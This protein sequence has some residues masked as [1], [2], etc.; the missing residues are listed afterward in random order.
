MGIERPY[1]TLA[2]NMMLSDDDPFANEPTMDVVEPHHASAA[3]VVCLTIVA[4][5]D[6]K[7]IGDRFLCRYSGCNERVPITRSSPCFAAPTG[8]SARAL[9]DPFLS[10]T[11]AITM[12]LRGVTAVA[13]EPGRGEVHIDGRILKGD[14]LM[15]RERLEN[16]V[17]IRLSSRIALMLHNMTDVSLPPTDLLVGHSRLMNHLRIQIR[18]AARQDGPVLILGSTGTGKELVADQIHRWS[19][20]AQ[21]PFVAIN[22]ATLVPT[23]AA[24]QLFGHRRGAF[25]GADQRHVGLFEHANQGTLLLDEIGDTPECVQPML[26]RTLETGRILPLGDVSEAAMDVRVIGATELINSLDQAPTR[27][28]ASLIYRLSSLTIQVPPLTQRRDD[29][30]R[31]L[32]HFLAMLD[33]GGSWLDRSVRDDVVWLRAD[34]MLALLEYHFP[35]N[36][37]E[38]K[39][40][41]V[42]MLAEADLRNRQLRL[43]QA[44]KPHC[45]SCVPLTHGEGRSRRRS[46]PDENALADLLKENDWSPSRVAHIL[47]IPNSTMHYWM[48]RASSIRRGTDLADVSA[49]LERIAHGE[50]VIDVARDLGV[51]PRALRLRLSRE[52][53]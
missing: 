50:Q 12:H 10:R 48:S 11:P 51:S 36:V 14:S 35:G 43:P 32:L 37:R 34:D 42:A 39:N 33:S 21:A 46:V 49:I 30:P 6:P 2:E 52:R 7:R 22:M 3:T 53:R 26:L 25:T 16:G 44:W 15:N 45:S 27:F 38:L 41:T 47:G 8:G 19:S 9:Q 20:R 17:I 5:P 24:A 23:T 18:N 1:P 31:L 40:I 29:I 4:H 13:L 28:R